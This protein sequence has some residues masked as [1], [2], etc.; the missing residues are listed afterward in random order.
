MPVRLAVLAAGRIIFGKADAAASVP[1]PRLDDGLGKKTENGDWLA[2]CDPVP[3]DPLP[4]A[5][6][7][8]KADVETELALGP[9]TLARA[10]AVTLPATGRNAL[11]L[12]GGT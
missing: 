10:G 12:S 5:G 9:R 2:I 7:V 6:S 1:G 11:W 3:G 4:A 8:A